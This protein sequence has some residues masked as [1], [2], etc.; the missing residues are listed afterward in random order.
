MQVRSIGGRIRE[1]RVWRG[2]T[3][4]ATA[5]LAGVTESYLSRIERNER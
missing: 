2:R 3:L 5:E 1:I 4:K